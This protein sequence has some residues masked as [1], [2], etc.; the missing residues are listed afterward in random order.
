[1]QLTIPKDAPEEVLKKELVLNAL[2]RKVRKPNGKY[3]H[4]KMTGQEKIA[5]FESWAKKD[6]TSFDAWGSWGCVMSVKT[7]S[8]P[9]WIADTLQTT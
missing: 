9:S 3:K 6:I 7:S 4:V 1:M 5:M 2:P 8:T